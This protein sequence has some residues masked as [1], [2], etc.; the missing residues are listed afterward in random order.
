MV[1]EEMTN[2]VL[3]LQIKGVNLTAREVIHI[4]RCLEKEAQ[5]QRVSFKNFLDDKV[6]SNS[7]PLKKMVNKGQLEKIPVSQQDLKQLKKQLNKHGVNFSVVKDKGS[8]EY[9]V[10]FQSSNTVIMERAFKK[11]IQ[12]SEKKIEARK[13]TIEKINK[14][15]KRIKASEPN[16]PEKT[17]AKVKDIEL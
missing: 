10:F 16:L 8:N 9:S 3:N 17:K 13:S 5:Q 4:L 15:K 14:F 2:R 11:A 7:I 1:N 12:D 6:K